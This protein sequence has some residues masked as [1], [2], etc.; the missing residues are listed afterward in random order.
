M[1]DW[2]S[3]TYIYTESRALVPWQASSL[4]AADAGAIINRTPKAAW[5]ASGTAEVE[6]S[7]FWKFETAPEWLLHG[8][9]VLF[10]RATDG[11]PVATRLVNGMD[12]RAVPWGILV[13]AAEVEESDV[14]TWTCTNGP[15]VGRTVGVS[16]EN[17]RIAVAV[18]A[19]FLRGTPPPARGT[20]FPFRRSNGAAARLICLKVTH[21][22]SQ[23]AFYQVQVEG[24]EWEGSL[25]RQG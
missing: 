17:P 20:I 8:Q 15:N 7:A 19:I 21:Q 11:S 16:L 23:G 1:A 5:A 12:G 22:W 14:K 10:S 18:T 9:R 25:T 3:Y 4:A 6:T 2:T 13:D 24:T